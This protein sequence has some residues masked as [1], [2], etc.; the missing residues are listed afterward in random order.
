M[1]WKDEYIKMIGCLDPEELQIDGAQHLK[2]KNMPRFLY[3]Y[4]P[5]SDYAIKNL[6]TDTVW[7]DSPS[8]YNDPFECVEYIDFNKLHGIN[9][10]KLVNDFFTKITSEYTVSDEILNN[11]KNSKKP[12]RALSE[13]ILRHYKNY[14]D[15]TIDKALDEFDFAMNKVSEDGFQQRNQRMQE[16]MK[17]C[18]FCESPNQL[19]M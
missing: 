13:H 14:D 1:S 7:V 3:K 19:L 9:T 10:D 4:R 2:E 18:S 17:V 16:N 5:A 6:D 12:V 11:L 8:E 15:D